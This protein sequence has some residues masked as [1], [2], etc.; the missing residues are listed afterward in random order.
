[1]T[2]P[3]DDISG[4]GSGMCAGAHCS[5]RPGLY[6][7][8]P[9]DNRVRG[10]ATSQTRLCSLLLLLPLALLL[11]QRWLAAAAFNQTPKLIGNIGWTKGVWWGWGDRNLTLPKKWKRHFG[12][13]VCPS[14]GKMDSGNIL[15]FVLLSF[16]VVWMW[17]VDVVI[18]WAAFNGFLQW[19][20][21][22]VD[23]DDEDKEDEEKMM[24]II[25]RLSMRIY[26]HSMRSI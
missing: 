15:Y 25:I 24:K 22:D 10:A 13:R 26:W 1:M 11:L 3:G 9:E 5:R 19:G 8:S 4:S 7:F 14:G 21:L 6:T 2:S 12:E 20:W 18:C 23:R 16:V 17:F